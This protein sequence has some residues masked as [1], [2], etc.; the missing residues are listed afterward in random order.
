LWPRPGRIFAAAR[1]HTFAELGTAIDDAFA[2]WDRHHLQQ[3][4]LDNG[5]RVSDPDPDFDEPG[6]VL[7]IA[8]TRLGRLVSGQQFVYVFDLGDCWTHLCT[9]ADGRIDPIDAIGI[10]PDLP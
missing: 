6:A 2:R 4:E 3:F 7:D 8:K 1:R 5:L 9:V 10:E